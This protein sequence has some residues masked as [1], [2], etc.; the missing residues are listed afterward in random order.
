[1]AFQEGNTFVYGE[2]PSASKM[3][4]LWRNDDAL[5]NGGLA[6]GAIQAAAIAAGAVTAP[7]LG[8]HT[9]GGTI[10]LSGTGS[11]AITGLGFQPRVIICF[12]LLSSGASNPTFFFGMA[13]PTTQNAFGFYNGTRRA[14]NVSAF[15]FSTDG[16]SDDTRAT[17]SS[18]DADGFTINKHVS[19][20]RDFMW[21]AFA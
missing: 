11:Q 15:L 18:F 9:K 20:G 17:V 3:D 6:A 8:T 21:L 10:S 16:T 12:L 7:K 14:S 1:M 5:Y 13:T 2:Q 4:Q 19:G